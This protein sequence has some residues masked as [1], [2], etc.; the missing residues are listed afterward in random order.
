MGREGM[1][2]SGTGR[3]KSDGTGRY[4]VG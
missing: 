1:G 3:D 2:S 4:M